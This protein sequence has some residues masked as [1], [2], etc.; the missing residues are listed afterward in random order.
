MKKIFI[1]AGEASGDILAADILKV[2]KSR[3]SDIEI[4]GIGGKLSLSAGL[5][6]S[7]FPMEELS[8][9]GIAEIVPKIPHFLKRIKETV[10]KIEDI[11]P[12]LILTVDSPEFSFRVQKN[13]KK[14]SWGGDI[15]QV[16]MVAPTV[17]AWR[18][19]RAKAISE[20]LDGLI[21]LFPFEP[22]YF[23]REGLPAI[24]TGH[25][26]IG[27][28]KNAPSQEEA[29]EFLGFKNDKK[30]V[31]VLF[32]SRRGELKKHGSVFCKTIHSVLTPDMEILVPTLPH[33]EEEVKSLVAEHFENQDQIL[34]VSDPSYQT[35][36]FK[37][38][39]CA[40]A[41]SGT[42]GLELAVAG[43]PHIIGYRVHP[44]TAPILRRMIKTEFAH[45]ANIIL[46][47]GVVPEFMYKE[48]REDVLSKALQNLLSGDGEVQKRDFQ[49][50]R[51]ILITDKPPA[52]T[53][54]DF[55]MRV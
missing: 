23:E 49:E 4:H 33:L 27:R 36:Y 1:I 21:C 8:I 34:I 45:L 11:K 46:G 48:C 6:K 37:A 50:L 16:H 29:R 10:Q 15:K 31:G 32:G 28:Y 18:P 52:E 43:T 5:E 26:V 19:D 22:P 24:Y 7:L 30:I 14:K 13:I 41:V 44:L 47:R 42:V 40:L 2:L 25:P 51:E 20:F 53:A 12:D 35:H 17:W 39:D 9:M 54:V 3:N 38:M 55:L